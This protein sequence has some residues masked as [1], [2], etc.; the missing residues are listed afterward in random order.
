MKQIPFCHITPMASNVCQQWV[1]FG[2][3]GPYQFFLAYCRD[4][5]SWGRAE[6]GNWISSGDVFPDSFPKPSEQN[7]MEVRFFSP[8]QELHLWRNGDQAWSGREAKD[9]GSTSQDDSLRPAWETRILMGDRLIECKHGFSHVGD[10]RGAHQAL[11]LETET[12]EFT[13]GL[14]PLRMKLRTY[15]RE[16]PLSGRVLPA[17]FRISQIY[18]QQRK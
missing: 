17:F 1:S 5:I 18:A 3:T 15:F 14:M 10:G 2:K 11:P 9:D 12:S 13:G 16:D 6:N 4:G 8:E 7:L